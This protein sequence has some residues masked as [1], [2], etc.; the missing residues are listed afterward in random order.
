M[1]NVPFVST[2]PGVDAQKR[3]PSGPAR[4]ARSGKRGVMRSVPSRARFPASMRITG[5]ERPGAQRQERKT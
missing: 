1:R 4:S 3:G 2:L 5:P